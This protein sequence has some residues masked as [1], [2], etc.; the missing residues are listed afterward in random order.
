MF[1]SPPRAL[2]RCV[3][4][5]LSSPTLYIFASFRVG[6]SD[7][8]RPFASVL[9]APSPA[10]VERPSQAVVNVP[11]RLIHRRAPRSSFS[12]AGDLSR[13]PFRLF[14]D[15]RRRDSHKLYTEH[16]KASGRTRSVYFLDQGAPSGAAVR[17]FV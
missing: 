16:W 1:V 8:T 3:L 6:P 9:T 13:V 4:P 14:S 7:S 12:G 15:R 17:N 2:H 5:S 10:A 11:W